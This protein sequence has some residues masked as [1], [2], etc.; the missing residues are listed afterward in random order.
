[1]TLSFTTVAFA[2]IF[3]LGNARSREHVVSPRRALA[4]RYALGAVLLTV[5]LQV[6]A[7]AAPPVA[8]VLGTEP[9]TT[10]GW[11]IAVGLGAIPALVGQGW[12]ILRGR[13]S[14]ISLS[15]FR[16]TP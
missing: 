13:S 4:N 1:M 16:Q 2:Q 10:R 14:G 5:T 3:H 9:L 15:S 12:K 11:M 7:V 6:L 8:R